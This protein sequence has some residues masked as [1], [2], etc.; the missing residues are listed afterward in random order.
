MLDLNLRGFSPVSSK[1]K[2][3]TLIELPLIC[4]PP[5]YQRKM[6]SGAIGDYVPSPAS[7]PA[8]DPVPAYNP[9]G[10]ISLVWY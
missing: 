7:V 8:Y 3:G 9:P 10:H 1:P 2:T 4:H 6:Y 5:I